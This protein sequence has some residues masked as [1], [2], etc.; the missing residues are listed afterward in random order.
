[1]KSAAQGDECPQSEKEKWRRPPPPADV[2]FSALPRAQ[3][4]PRFLAQVVD[5]TRRCIDSPRDRE[6]SDQ[7]FESQ[8]Q[9]RSYQKEALGIALN[10]HDAL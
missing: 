7:N 9:S 5:Y 1:M 6:N 8:I 2:P 3:Y 4:F 10:P